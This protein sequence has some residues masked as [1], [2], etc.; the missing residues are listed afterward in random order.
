MD[1]QGGGRFG[2]RAPRGGRRRSRFDDVDDSSMTLAEWEAK[3]K[4]SAPTS[5]GLL[6]SVYFFRSSLAAMLFWK[7]YV[8]LS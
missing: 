1:I 7:H 4:G 8:L 2:G 5:N 3:A 6:A